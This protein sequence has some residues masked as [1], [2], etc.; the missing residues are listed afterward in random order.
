MTEREKRERFDKW[1]GE[2]FRIFW[3]DEEENDEHLREVELDNGAGSVP[4]ER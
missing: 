2:A 1:V 3:F 4:E